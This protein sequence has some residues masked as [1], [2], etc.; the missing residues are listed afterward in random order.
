MKKSIIELNEKIIKVKDAV[1]TDSQK[2]KYTF[3]NAF[4][5]FEKNEFIGDGIKIDFLKEVL[6]TL[7][8]IHD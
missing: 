3:E 2:N 7:K 5:D 6:E 8:M 4:I 1:L